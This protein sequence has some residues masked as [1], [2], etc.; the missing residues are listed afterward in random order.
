MASLQQ[1]RHLKDKGYSL[2]ILGS[3]WGDE[4]KGK[5]VDLLTERANTV[6]RFQGGHNA[7]HTLVIQGEKTALRLLPSGI[8]RE[9]VD[10]FIG[11][12]VVVSPTTLI[13]EIQTLEDRGISVR[14]RL[15]VCA[16]CPL[17]L[18]YHVAL[19]QAREKARGKHAIGTTGRGIG[20]AYEDKV[21]RQGLRLLDLTN[22]TTFADKLRER[23]KYYNFIL[24]Q[25]YQANPVD[26]QS[27]LDELQQAADIIVPLIADVPHQLAQLRQ[28]GKVII[29]EGAQGT[30]LDIDHGTYPFVTSSNTTA[31]SAAN[32]SGL[33][34]RD[35]DYILGITKAYTTRVGQ[36]AISM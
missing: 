6:V 29:F 35:L 15:H 18:P 22:Q 32:G 36:R 17:V 19:D 12:G 14:Q 26:Y 5:I 1:R 27:V 9:H 23:V 30:L 3:Q 20:P 24:Q 8:L 16:T 11:N 2:V 13:K 28:A 4:G 7:G 21:S 34:P 33:G 31:G 25:Y 10:C